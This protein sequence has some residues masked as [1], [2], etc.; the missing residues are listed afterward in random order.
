MQTLIC[1]L[2]KLAKRDKK[3]SIK[4]ICKVSE[5]PKNANYFDTIYQVD[6]VYNIYMT[7]SGIYYAAENKII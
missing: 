7:I 3:Y 6:K 4:K 5:M 1:N 2:S